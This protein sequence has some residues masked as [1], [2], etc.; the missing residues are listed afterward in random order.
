LIREVLEKMTIVLSPFTPHIAEEVWEL[1]GHA[2]LVASTNWPEFDPD[3]AKEE[4]IEI[5]VQINGKIRSRFYA[6]LDV[7]REVME[8]TALADPKIQAFL[9]EGQIRKVIVVPGR[10]V[11]LVV[12]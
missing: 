4:E 8:E 1:T 10:L 9:K 7:T 6:P 11:N 5:V 2:D 12:N 3:L